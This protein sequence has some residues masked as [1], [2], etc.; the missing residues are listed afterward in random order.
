MKIKAYTLEQA[1][2]ELK[3]EELDLDEPKFGEVL[4]KV[5]ASGICHTDVSGIA[6]SFGLNQYPVVLGHEGAGIIEKL[7]PGVQGY[8]VGD[9]V[10]MSYPFCGKCDTCMAGYQHICENG[11]PLQYNGVMADGTGRLS[12]NGKPIKNFFLQSSFA[13]YSVMEAKQL[14]KVD[15][16]VDLKMFAPLG[17]GALTGAGT[18]LNFW[19]CGNGDTVAIIG[20]GGVGMS[21]MMAA[22]AS[23]CKKIIMIDVNKGRLDLSLSLGATD[24]INVKEVKDLTA[25]IMTITGGKGVNYLVETSG[26]TDVFNAASAALAVRGEAGII[27]PDM[28]PTE[29][30][31][32]FFYLYRKTMHCIVLGMTTPQAIIPKMLELNKRGLFPYEKLVKQYKFEDMNQAIADMKSGVTVKPVL[33]MP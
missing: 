9:H 33:V 12:R 20:A 6:N 21:A 16:S 3:L 5:V 1:N 31:N 7:G 32:L 10:L 22:H 26:K 30:G 25:E 11:I 19:K 17:C 27:A 13:T 14:V 8:E 15:K 18:I 23:N 2:A 24:V 4:I 29:V 28:S